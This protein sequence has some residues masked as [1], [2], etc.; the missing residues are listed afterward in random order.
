MSHKPNYLMSRGGVWYARA[1]VNGKVR[2]KSLGTRSRTVAVRKAKLLVEEWRLSEAPAAMPP[3]TPA[4]QPAGDGIAVSELAAAYRE[5]ARGYY[6]GPD[7]VPTDQ[8]SLVQTA[9]QVL[10]DDAGDTRVDTFRPT[11]L[12]RIQD[13]LAASGRARRTVNHYVA[14]IKRVFKWGVSRD[15][16]PVEVFTALTTVEGLRRGRSAAKETAPVTAVDVEVVEKTKRFLSPVVQALVTVHLQTGARS[17]ELVNLRVGDIDRTGKV[18]KAALSDHKTAHHGKQ[19]A[20]FFGPVAQAALAPLLLGREA[21]EY[22]F[23]PREAVKQVR[24]RRAAERT[25]PLS[26]GNRP[27]TNRKRRPSTGPGAHYTP[28]TYGHAIKRAITRYNAWA[29]QNGEEPIEHWHPHQL[30]HTA[31]TLLR[32]QYGLDAAQVVLGHSSA[33]ITQLYAE[34]NDEKAAAIMAEI[35]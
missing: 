18:W 10:L 7:G 25:T 5:W 27:G 30:R 19:R 2:M 1:K 26:C 35:G 24:A 22:V 8:M 11:D 15:M 23:S 12:R 3:A 28:N 4:E 9:T 14:T 32:E 29:E 21:D 33:S 20:L 16:V 31:A 17:G 34:L 6:R 13:A